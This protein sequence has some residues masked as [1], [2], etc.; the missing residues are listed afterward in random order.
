M[1]GKK[2]KTIR[3]FLK[4]RGEQDNKWMY[5]MMKDTL[6]GVRRVRK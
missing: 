1:R 5:R 3:R 6:K 2:C 4:D